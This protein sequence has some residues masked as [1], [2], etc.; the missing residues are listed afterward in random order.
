MERVTEAGRDGHRRLR[1]N[2]YWTAEQEAML[3]ELVLT[4]W[5]LDDPFV[6]NEPDRLNQQEAATGHSN[7]TI[8]GV[9]VLSS[10]SEA[11]KGTSS[12]S[13]GTRH[14]GLELLPVAHLTESLGGDIYRKVRSASASGSAVSGHAIVLDA[15]FS[16]GRNKG[17]KQRSRQQRSYRRAREKVE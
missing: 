12:E 16:L 4:R 9:Q 3:D 2:R 14:G 10:R 17:S 11:A 7:T 8:G 5:T 6:E 13:Q 1:R 15:S